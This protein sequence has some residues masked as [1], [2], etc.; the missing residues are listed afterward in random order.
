MFSLDLDRLLKYWSTDISNLIYLYY[1]MYGLAQVAAYLSFNEIYLLG[2]GLS[3]KYLNP[4]MLFD[5]GLDPERYDWDKIEYHKQAR[6][7]RIFFRSLIKGI[8]MKIIT[9]NY[10]D[11]DDMLKR[12]LR[13]E[14]VE[15]F[16]SDYLSSLRISDGPRYDRELT[17]GHVTIKRV[18]EHLGVDVYNATVGGELEVYPRVDI[19]DLV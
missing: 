5:D 2:A 17:K 16:A 12:I 11:L 15:H 7:K 18:C 8:L 19:H 6:R 4:H 9:T 3:V 10:V 14:G 13:K 1:S